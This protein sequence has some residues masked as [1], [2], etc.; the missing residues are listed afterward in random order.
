MSY[1]FD[2]YNYYSSLQDGIL[3]NQT[4]RLDNIESS[5]STK[6]ALI[7]YNIEYAAWKDFIIR[8][9]MIFFIIVLVLVIPLVGYLGNQISIYTFFFIVFA[10]FACY[11]VV[12]WW[13]LNTWNVNS[14]SKPGV[15]VLGQ[16]IKDIG[17]AIYREGNYITTHINKWINNKCACKTKYPHQAKGGTIIDNINQSNNQPSD[18]LDDGS[19]KDTNN[20]FYYYDGSAPPQK[21][22]QP[23]NTKDNITWNPA[24][25][26]GSRTNARF[27]P[28]PT[29]MTETVGLPRY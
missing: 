1:P 11:G 15:N 25:D 27:T 28:P 4:N 23:P 16:D 14:W 12:L 9:L 19:I 7:R 20:Y 13:E 29:W 22:P 8:H 3:T 21:I 2:K 5:I 18:L 26:M 6:D 10:T 24:P 17:D